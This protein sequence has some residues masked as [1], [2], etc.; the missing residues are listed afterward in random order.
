[1]IITHNYYIDF[2]K[3]FDV[4]LRNILDD[5]ETTFLSSQNL[6]RIENNFGSKTVLTHKLYGDES[7]EYPNAMID[8]QDIKP[9]DNVIPISQHLR[10]N[11]NSLDTFYI[12]S[13]KTK[14]TNIFVE[15]R[16][17]LIDLNIKINVET[18]ADLLNYYHIILNKLPVNFTFVDYNFGMFINLDEIGTEDQWDLSDDM[19]NIFKFSN[20]TLRDYES[21]STVFTDQPMFELQSISK[22]EDKENMKYS[23]NISMLCT[24]RIPYKINYETPQ[25]IKRIIVSIDTNEVVNIPEDLYPVLIDNDLNE[26]NKIQKGLFLDQKEDIEFL[27]DKIN[28]FI[29]SEV[30]NDLK[31]NQDKK[32]MLFWKINDKSYNIPLNPE[33]KDILLSEDKLNTIQVINKD[34]VSNINEI[35]LLNDSEF[36]D[37]ENSGYNPRIYTLLYITP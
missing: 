20:N 23:V 5:S 9:F 37:P 30:F 19:Y 28:I 7:Y 6:Q 35:K 12:A 16:L 25:E 10:P 4:F 14:N 1:M 3:S 29:D 18:S 32:I 31:N 2:L 26:F 34:I 13:N 33:L 27:E 21:W 8:I 15:T 17:M 22:T 11:N 36:I 24:F